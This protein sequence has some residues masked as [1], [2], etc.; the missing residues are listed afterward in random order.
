[1]RIIAPAATA[2]A[3]RFLGERG[4]DEEAQVREV[5]VVAVTEHIEV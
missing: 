2:N 3:T 1:M 5:F 4:F